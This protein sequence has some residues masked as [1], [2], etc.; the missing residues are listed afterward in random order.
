MKKYINALLFFAQVAVCAAVI[1]GG[2][3]LI[4]ALCAATMPLLDA[5]FAWFAARALPI[6][7]T[8]VIGFVLWIFGDICDKQAR[9]ERN[10]KC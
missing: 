5:L 1:L 3:R 6:V 9:E 2:V 10:G 4:G 7:V 8:V